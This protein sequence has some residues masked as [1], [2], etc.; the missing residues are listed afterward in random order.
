VALAGIIGAANLLP[1]RTLDK[2]K[3]YRYVRGEVRALAREHHFGKSLVF[4]RSNETNLLPWYSTSFASAFLLNP[5]TLDPDESGTVYVR[6]LGP[7]SVARIRAAY[8][9]RPAWFIQAPDGL[10]GHFAVVRGPIPPSSH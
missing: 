2:Y 3:N 7:A 5:L 9:G 4:I 8:P 6:D 10:N 1:W